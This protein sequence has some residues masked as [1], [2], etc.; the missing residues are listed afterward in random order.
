MEGETK[1]ENT[2]K[3]FSL[4]VQFVRACDG[5]LFVCVVSE[6]QERENRPFEA[7]KKKTRCMHR[8]LLGD[9]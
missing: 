3:S 1:G 4:C 2:K 7:Q 6:M 9:D 8:D 5:C